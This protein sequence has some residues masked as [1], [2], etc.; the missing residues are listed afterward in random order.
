MRRILIIG[1]LLALSLTLAVPAFA[2]DSTIHIVLRGENLFRIGLRYGVTVDALVTANSLSNAS[3]IYV[4][5]RLVIPNGSTSSPPA[6]SSVHIVQPG[7]TLSRIALQHGVTSQAIAAANGIANPN[8]I[9]VG[10][11]LVIPGDN[12]TPPSSSSQTYTVQ[13]G[14]TLSAIAL[15]F[16]VST[17]SLAQTNNIR[18]PALIYVG[19]VLLIP[20]GASTSNPPTGSRWI[21]IDLSAQRVTAYVGNTAVRSTLASTGLPATPTPTG[22]FYIYVKYVSTLMTGPGYYLPNVPYTM[23]FYHGYGIHGTYWH[24]NFGYPMS[25]GCVNLP[26]SEAQWF[27]NWASVGT[28]V[29]I[30]Y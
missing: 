12:G 28:L 8:L 16:G 6:S 18:N 25:H 2:Q 4:G 29:N 10:Q 27:F 22:Q 9:Y 14:D 19:Q 13:P 1:I 7:E 15:R 26:T 11:R 5:Q 17:W 3:H 23:Y 30:H 24:S 21:D 20:S